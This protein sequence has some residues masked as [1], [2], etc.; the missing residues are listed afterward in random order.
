MAKLQAPKWKLD[1]Q[2][3]VS[4]IYLTNSFFFIWSFWT[5]SELEL[6]QLP[7][8]WTKLTHNS[9]IYFTLFLI[10][11]NYLVFGLKLGVVHDRYEW[12][13]DPPLHLR[14]TSPLIHLV[15]APTKLW[16][17]WKDFQLIFWFSSH[18]CHFIT[19]WI[20]MSFPQVWRCQM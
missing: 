3:I 8:I 14:L 6:C 11:M 7:V 15:H 17:Y 9:E 10:L 5:F 4:K 16:N 18:V 1:A 20:L 13:R 12:S 2:F 19:S